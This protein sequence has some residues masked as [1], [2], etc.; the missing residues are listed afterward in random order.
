MSE[1]YEKDTYLNP[2]IIYLFNKFIYEYDM[3]NAGFNYQESS[4]YY[5]KI[6]LMNLVE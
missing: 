4:N 1:L 3:R 2:N 5:Q 6:N